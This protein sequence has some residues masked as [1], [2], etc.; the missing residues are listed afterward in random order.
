MGCWSHMS[1]VGASVCQCV[2]WEALP[3]LCV[4]ATLD[5]YSGGVNPPK[6]D[7]AHTVLDLETEHRA[8]NRDQPMNTTK[9][10]DHFYTQ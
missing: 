7:S 3:E 8:L 10:R 2:V 5:G 6:S 1:L 9:T 4:I